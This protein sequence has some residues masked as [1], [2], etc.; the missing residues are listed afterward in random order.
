M[1]I[2]A[3]SSNPGLASSIASCLECQLVDAELTT[4][5]N[6]ERRVWIK[7]DLQG[8]NV[9]LV[10]SFSHPT[11]QNI[12]E[13]LLLIDALE[14]MG[15]RHVNLVMPW[16]GYSMQD[17]VFRHGEP[18]AAKVV[19]NLVSNA[20]TKRVFV[21]DLHNSSTPGFF[22][23]PTMQLSAME[24]FAD[25]ARQTFELD[26]AVVASPDFG[27]LKRARMFANLLDLEL[28]NIDKHRN[29]KTG[30]V[31]AVGLH[32]EVEGKNVLVFDDVIISGSTV[33]ESAQ[34]LKNEGASQVQFFSSHGLFINQALQRFADSAVDRVIT[35]NSVAQPDRPELL[36][37]LDLGPLFTEALQKWVK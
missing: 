13:S 12:I 19:A 30:K 1:H 9:A 8:K 23:V 16:M 3:G 5:A 14:R 10:Q 32:G 4:F 11:D 29:L 2:I 6:G 27:G 33:M 28:V 25:H 36:T 18:I 31:T 17:K 35:T 15:V 37:V 26:K 24:M 20:Y 7:D 34:L 21:L 22:S